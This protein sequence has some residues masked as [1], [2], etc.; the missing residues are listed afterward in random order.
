MF[1]SYLKT[2]KNIYFKYLPISLGLSSTYYMLI[3]NQNLNDDINNGHLKYHKFNPDCPKYII[4]VMEDLQKE[5]KPEPNGEIQYE[6]YKDLIREKQ[7]L[8]SNI[9]LVDDFVTLIISGFGYP[10]YYSYFVVK[11]ISPSFVDWYKYKF[12]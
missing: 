7:Y 3:N 1:A 5:F 9:V 2:A 8:C 4:T 6:N 12:R 10:I 11:T